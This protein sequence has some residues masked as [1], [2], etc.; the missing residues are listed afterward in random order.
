MKGVFKGIGVD[1]RI[2]RPQKADG[3]GFASPHRRVVLGDEDLIRLVNTYVQEYRKKDGTAN[4][5]AIRT[6]LGWNV[7]QWSAFKEKSGNLINWDFIPKFSVIETP[8]VADPNGVKNSLAQRGISP[9][10]IAHKIEVTYGQLRRDLYS[11]GLTR[12]E[13]DAAVAMQNF[14]ENRFANA[15]EM[16]SS[17]V[18]QM[19]IKL[20][21]EQRILERRLKEVRTQ[22]ESFAGFASHER[23]CWVNEEQR[24]IKSYATVGKLMSE[25]QDTWYQ[26]SAQLALLRMRMREDGPP[27]GSKFPTQR[28]GKPSFSPRIMEAEQIL[29]EQPS[30]PPANDQGTDPVGNEEAAP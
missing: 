10:E 11:I 7:A 9:D 24:L 2:G 20:Q 21:T 29:P 1:K 16:I 8:E 22:I 17:G 27:S 3:H 19:S 25:I 12:Q 18:F 26:G 14:G 6:K 13:V 28:S 30:T 4:I 23:D 5:T 15:M